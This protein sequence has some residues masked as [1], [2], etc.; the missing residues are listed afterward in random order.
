MTTPTA[1][2]TLSTATEWDVEEPKNVAIELPFSGPRIAARCITNVQ[3]LHLPEPCIVVN[4][5]STPAS[6]LGPGF[7]RI[8]FLQSSIFQN[9]VVDQADRIVV[10]SVSNH[11]NPGGIVFEPGWVRYWTLLVD[12]LGEEGAK[13]TGFSPETPL[14][15]SP[16]QSVGSILVDPRF[17]TGQHATPQTRSPF[18]IKVNLWF[19]PEGTDCGIHNVHDFIEVHTQAH[20]VG[21]MQKFRE[22]EFDTLYE[23]VVMGEGYTTPVPFCEVDRD[24]AFAYPWHQYRADGDCVWMA[25]ELHP[26]LRRLE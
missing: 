10:L 15:R 25:I 8:P 3:R 19:A 13:A 21:R 2:N 4:I 18:E 9:V 20:G 5:G 16:Q 1:I 17:V 23:D 12:Q 24:G 7:K 26:I 14:W 11:R 6:F 22:K